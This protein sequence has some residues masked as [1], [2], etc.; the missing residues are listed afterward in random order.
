MVSQ[1]DALLRYAGIL[2]NENGVELYPQGG[3]AQLRTDELISLVD[4]MANSWAPRL[5]VG[6][7]TEEFRIPGR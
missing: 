1:S 2:A 5:C 6:Y 3:M 4:E 7:A